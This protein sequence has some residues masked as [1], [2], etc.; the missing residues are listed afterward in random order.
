[1]LKILFIVSGKSSAPAYLPIIKGLKKKSKVYLLS[2]NNLDELKHFDNSIEIIK[3]SDNVSNRDNLS[4]KNYLRIIKDFFLKTPYFSNI[5]IFFFT[6]LKKTFFFKLTIKIRLNQLI[7]YQ[8]KIN[9]IFSKY[10]FDRVLISNDRSNDLNLLVCKYCFNNQIKSII[11]PTASIAW[12]EV[13]LR[14]R[15]DHRDYYGFFHNKTFLKYPFLYKYDEVLKKN[16]SYYSIFD[17]LPYDK[18]NLLPKNPW[19]NGG[20]NS[21][22]RLVEGEYVSKISI[23]NGCDK[24]KII[25]VGHTDY[26]ELYLNFQFKSDI[27]KFITKK[28][29]IRK[30]KIILVSL[31]PAYEHNFFTKEEA[32]KIYHKFAKTLENLTAHILIS[33]HPKMN[34]EDYI[35]LEEMYGL[36]IIDEKLSKILP[37]VDIFICTF[38]STVFH[39][40]LSNV[41]VTVFDVFNHKYKLLDWIEN[42]KI[43]FSFVDLKNE[44]MHLLEDEEYANKVRASQSSHKKY[45]LDNFDG[46]CVEKIIKEIQL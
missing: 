40:I 15:R 28:Y 6:L 10:K 43:S 2:T 23:E 38:S 39:S 26:D 14:Q 20:G 29:C 35:F 31:P 41:V 30:T 24:S 27:R 1:M 36:N 18:L 3:F 4:S 25:K 44:I 21:N 9:T 16:I 8:E 32:L 11:I 22:L 13:I 37:S 34:R 33:L 5:I 19:V 45:I 46:K 12:P 7:N 17:I 42:L